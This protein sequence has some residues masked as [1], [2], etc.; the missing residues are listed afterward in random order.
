MLVRV[1]SALPKGS[2]TDRTFQR[3]STIISRSSCTP[4]TGALVTSASHWVPTDTLRPTS[5]DRSR[6]WTQYACRCTSVC[7]PNGV[8]CGRRVRGMGSKPGIKWRNREPPDSVFRC[9]ICTRCTL[10][11]Q[12]CCTYDTCATSKGLSEKPRFR[13]TSVVPGTGDRSRMRA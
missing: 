4:S 12:F 3:M 2:C 8:R 9:L 11:Y 1:L 13:N 5:T 10:L 7:T 6:K